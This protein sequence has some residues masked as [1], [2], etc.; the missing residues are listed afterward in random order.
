MSFNYFLTGTNLHPKY[1][2]PSSCHEVTLAHQKDPITALGI[3]NPPNEPAIQA[4]A[5]YPYKT[6]ADKC[7]KLTKTGAVVLS[8][9]GPPAFVVV[10]DP[11]DL[12]GLS[13]VDVESVGIEWY[14]GHIQPLNLTAERVDPKGL[15]HGLPERQE[16]GLYIW[17]GTSKTS[18]KSPEWRT[19]VPNTVSKVPE[20][21]PF[22][23][24]A[25]IINDRIGYIYIRDLMERYLRP[26]MRDL[27]DNITPWIQD[28]IDGVYEKL[29]VK[30]TL[31]GPLY[32]G[33]QERG[34][35]LVKR[36]WYVKEDNKPLR[37]SNAVARRE[38]RRGKVRK[39]GPDR[40]KKGWTLVYKGPRPG[41][42]PG[43]EY[44]DLK[45]PVRVSVE[46]E[47][48]QDEEE[49]EGV[50][51]EGI[52]EEGGEEE[53]TEELDLGL[54]EDDEPG[55]EEEEEEAG[56][57]TIL[58]SADLPQS[59]RRTTKL[60]DEPQDAMQ[61]EEYAEEWGDNERT[62]NAYYIG[63]DDWNDQKEEE[64]S[65]ERLEKASNPLPESNPEERQPVLANPLQ[66]PP[67]A[68]LPESGIQQ[69]TIAEGE[70]E[71]SIKQETI[72]EEE[73]LKQEEEV[74][75]EEPN[76]AI[77]INTPLDLNIPNNNQ[78][79]NTATDVMREQLQALN[80]VQMPN[81]NDPEVA[82]RAQELQIS[83]HRNE[84][85]AN[86]N[87][88]WY[89]STTRDRDRDGNININT[90]IMRDIE[91]V[92]D[93]NSNRRTATTSTRRRNPYLD[94]ELGEG[95]EQ[96]PSRSLGDYEDYED[97]QGRSIRSRGGNSP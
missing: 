72:T 27:E 23:H 82:T 16:A 85:L 28:L 33:G 34:N 43:M 93:R 38:G 7:G 2:S 62:A 44:F 36:N 86:I 91:D 74:V 71:G 69:E 20:P 21:Q 95:G 81:I 60:Q 67:S 76:T 22:L 42:V 66:L 97:P 51:D 63:N 15:L 17:S 94:Q 46:G 56:Y 40:E 24:R 13:V 89:S 1:P 58:S 29:K 79:P 87:P 83:N 26:D 32:K 10:L 25:D 53:L 75:A 73:E 52:F 88:F 78:P 8:R 11:T 61:I 41:E 47:D 48:G 4:L 39:V 35:W 96:R 30:P 50:L 19:W 70:E 57:Q 68:I 45:R 80:R 12:Y 3:Y 55:P 77:N 49:E 18:F 31:G 90:N 65:E 92:E 9:G 84:M 37:R 59:L 5:V 6:N 54:S 14:R 64:T